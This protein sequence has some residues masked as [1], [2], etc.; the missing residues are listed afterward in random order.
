MHQQTSIST[1]QAADGQIYECGDG[2][3]ASNIERSNPTLVAHE[4]EP[5]GPADIEQTSSTLRGASIALTVVGQSLVAGTIVA[6]GDPLVGAVAAVTVVVC[7]LTLI[8]AE[9]VSRRL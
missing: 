4:P 6:G 1:R 5:D 3:P 7:S 9:V 8:T 2:V